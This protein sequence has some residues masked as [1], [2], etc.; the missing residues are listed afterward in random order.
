M[1]DGRAGPGLRRRYRARSRAAWPPSVPRGRRG[2]GDA[3]PGVH[4]TLPGGAGP[5]P[6]GGSFHRPPALPGDSRRPVVGLG[7]RG[8]GRARNAPLAASCAAARPS[9][10]ASFW[11]S[12]R[13][14][15]VSVPALGPRA[16]QGYPPQGAEAWWSQRRRQRVA[17]PVRHPVEHLREHSLHGGVHAVARKAL[18]LRNV[19]PRRR[20]QRVVADQH[21][22]RQA[23][24]GE[25]DVVRLLR[26][27]RPPRRA[28]RSSRLPLRRRATRPRPRHRRRDAGRPARTPR[29]PARRRAPPSRAASPPLSRPP[30]SSRPSPR[31]ALRQGRTRP[32]ACRRTTGT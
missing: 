5:P 32:S 12:M 24:D 30:A 13:K 16:G 25:H 11:L 4:E 26:P 22:G 10:G 20:A 6:H 29:P 23:V 14:M 28:P 2:R 19:I 17:E 31:G 1:T 7:G 21:H 8:A 9:E 18:G 27:S 15:R 3:P